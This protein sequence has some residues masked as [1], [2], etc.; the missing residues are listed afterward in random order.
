MG[1]WGKDS[2][3][4]LHLRKRSLARD[5]GGDPFYRG[6]RQRKPGFWDPVPLSRPYSFERPSETIEKGALGP[7]DGLWPRSVAPGANAE[8][9]LCTGVRLS[10]QHS[11][12]IPPDQPGPFLHA[13]ICFPHGPM[14]LCEPQSFF[15][16]WNQ[17]HSCR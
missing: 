8:S 14:S 13:S 5:M 2:G 10:H 6:R 16:R 12:R 4:L 1:S 11:S 17:A 15:W 9:V 3:I 7:L